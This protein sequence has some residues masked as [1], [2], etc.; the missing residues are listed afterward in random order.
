MSSNNY[1]DLIEQIKTFAG[2][3]ITIMDMA[4]EIEVPWRTLSGIMTDLKLRG[5]DGYRITNQRKYVKELNTSIK[6]WTITEDASAKRVAAKS[7]FTRSHA[8]LV[9]QPRTPKTP[10]PSRA[11]PAEPLLRPTQINSVYFAL[12]RKWPIKFDEVAA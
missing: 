6:V 4:E 11:K 7:G 1:H 12:T 10:R 9:K 8:V 3:Q 2:R 5:L